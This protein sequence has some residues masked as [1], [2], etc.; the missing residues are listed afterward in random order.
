MSKKYTCLF[1]DLDGT[2]ADSEAGILRSMQYAIKEL[3]LPARS[4][5]ALRVHVGAPLRE[6]FEDEFGISIEQAEEAVKVFRSYYV[7]NEADKHPPFDGVADLLGDLK[8]AGRHLALA[9]S[10][11]TLMAEKV[12]KGFGMYDLFDVIYGSNLDNSRASKTEVLADAIEAMTTLT[13]MG[14]EDMLMIG[15]K[16][17]DVEAARTLGLDVM[18]VLYGY[19]T[20]AEMEACRPT[21]TVKTV[22]DLRMFLLKEY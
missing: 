12:L 10:K 19:G 3:E 17:Y 18:G 21:Y 8:K 14:K 22:Q 2:L 16:H 20:K 6:M 1:F 7:P 11:P 15:D 9:T 5:D 4:D 13:G